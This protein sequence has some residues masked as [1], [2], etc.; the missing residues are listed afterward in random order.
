MVALCTA[1]EKHLV[2]LFLSTTASLTVDE[3]CAEL[4]GAAKT[5]ERLPTS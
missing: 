2:S 5:L 4:Q 3:L 1:T